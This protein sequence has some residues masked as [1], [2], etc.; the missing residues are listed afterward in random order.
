MRGDVAC[1]AFNNRIYFAGGTTNN[2]GNAKEVDIYN[3][4]TSHGVRFIDHTQADAV[5]VVI[6]TKIYFAGGSSTTASGVTKTVSIYDDAT[7]LWSQDSFHSDVLRL[8]VLP[9]ETLQFLPAVIKTLPPI[10]PQSRRYF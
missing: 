4:S 7:G 3:T 5:P 6:G 8:Q 1:V 9:L 2:F 10:P